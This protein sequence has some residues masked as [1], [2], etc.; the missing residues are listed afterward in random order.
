MASLAVS[1][2]PSKRITRGLSNLTTLLLGP[3][4][5]S[6]GH[7]EGRARVTLTPLAPPSEMRPAP[8]PGPPSP[9][10]TPPLIE[11]RGLAVLDQQALGVSLAHGPRPPGV[12]G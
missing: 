3:E 10:T 1:A 8:R 4:S 9:I 12:E 7:G 6:S 5:R 11:A 2:A